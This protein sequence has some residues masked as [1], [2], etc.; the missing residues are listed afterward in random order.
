M[1]Q[2][3]TRGGLRLARMLDEAF[4]PPPPTEARPAR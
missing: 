3:V 1:R 4:G 2:Q